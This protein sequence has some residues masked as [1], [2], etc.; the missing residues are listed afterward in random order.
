[1]RIERSFVRAKDPERI[2]ACS[3]GV[4]RSDTPGLRPIP[5]LIP[6]GLKIRLASLRDALTLVHPPGVSLTLNPRLM[7]QVLS[8]QKKRPY[9]MSICC[10]QQIRI[11]YRAA[12]VK[13][14]SPGRLAR[15]H[16]GRSGLVDRVVIYSAETVEDDRSTCRSV[17]LNRSGSPNAPRQLRI[18]PPGDWLENLG[19]EVVWSIEWW[20]KARKRSRTTVRHVDLLSSTDLDR[21][22]RRAS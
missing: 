1:M 11:A 8:G 5:S 12:P 16:G 17:V 15:E 7:A 22:T 9:D 4:E 10:P 21:L 18:F 13:N 3:R 19:G 14:L 6:K 20:S 2:E